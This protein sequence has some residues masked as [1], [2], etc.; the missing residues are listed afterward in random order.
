MSTPSP[1]D[2]CLLAQET[3]GNWRIVTVLCLVVILD[4]TSIILLAIYG[5][6][7][8]VNKA[9]HPNLKALIISLTFCFIIRNTLTLIRASRML[10]SGLVAKVGI[11]GTLG[12][13]LNNDIIKTKL[14]KFL[15]KKF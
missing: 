4:I 1:L 9:I 7:Y 11:F 14:F 8:F 2:E 3:T 15:I 6:C 5:H 10:I 12:A 13:K